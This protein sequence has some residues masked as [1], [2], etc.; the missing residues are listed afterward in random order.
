MK[1]LYF[2]G[3]EELWN[4]AWFLA[5]VESLKSRTLNVVL[6][7]HVRDAHEIKIAAEKMTSYE[8][9]IFHK[10]LNP[11]KVF[12]DLGLENLASKSAWVFVFS[13]IIN[14][15]AQPRQISWEADVEDVVRIIAL[16]EASQVLEDAFLFDMNLAGE[17][18]KA[19]EKSE[20]SMID[21]NLLSADAE[22]MAQMI[23]NTH[24]QFQDD[25]QLGDVPL[26]VEA[27]QTNVD[28]K[29]EDLAFLDLV[30]SDTDSQS[31]EEAFDISLQLKED[32]VEPRATKIIQPVETS[33][34]NLTIEPVV[35]VPTPREE[36]KTV[37]FPDLES[38]PV[39]SPSVEVSQLISAMSPSVSREDM[40][41]LKR[42]SSLK[43]RELRESQASIEALRKQ[44][45]YFDERLK[46]SEEERRKLLLKLE[47]TD[48]ELRTT[49]DKKDENRA[50]L[51]GIES[52]YEEKIKEL[53]V[54]LES[55]QFQAGKLDKKLTDFRERVRNDL[56]KIR[57]RERELASRL[58]IQKRDAEALLSAKD[59]RLL[60]QKR[61]MDRL[62]F[63]LDALKERLIDDVQKG[64][65]RR[66]R[67]SRALQSLK[68]AQSI[69][70]GLEED[71]FTKDDKDKAA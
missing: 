44:I 35:P 50:Q 52:R 23:N 9:M 7:D 57:S 38:I 22:Q 60:N 55:S 65:E 16:G 21:E 54:Q 63:D 11:Q 64:E 26:K 15:S 29:P 42:Y 37:E 67:V 45:R 66:K 48:N 14:E 49:S 40:D 62:E 5:L 34:V 43:E 33:H 12:A 53:L 71:V 20:N 59:E 51:R 4:N 1:T 70:A 58:E 18:S 2:V 3:N 10:T 39:A 30:A 69:L 19:I 6:L 41:V 36:N 13:D 27:A 68:L 17:V 46:K 32:E 56:Q 31:A 28:I 8:R 24:T 25:T 61:E 47:E